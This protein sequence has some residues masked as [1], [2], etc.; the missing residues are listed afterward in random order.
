MTDE[1]AWRWPAT[2]QRAGRGRRRRRAGPRRR[3]AATSADRLPIGAAGHEHAA[4]AGGQPGEVGDPAQRLVL[5]V[6]RAGALEPRAAVDGRGADDEVEQRA[7][8]VGRARDERQVPGVVDR[9][10]RR[11][12][13]VAKTPA[14]RGRR[15][16][17]RD[18]LRRRPRPARPRSAGRRAAAGP[19]AA[20]QRRSRGP[21]RRA[22]PTSSSKACTRVESTA[23]AGRP[24][25]P[26]H[27]ARY[28]GRHAGA[29]TWSQIIDPGWAQALAPG[30]RRCARWATSSGRRSRPGAGTCRAATT[31]CARS[32]SR[33]TTCASSSSART[34]TRRRATRSGLLLG[35]SRRPAAA[36]E[37]GEHLHRAA[38]RP[39]R[40]RPDDRRP[41]PVDGAGRPAAQP[42]PHRGPRQAGEPPGQGLGDGH[43][44]AIEALVARGGPLVAVLWGR[45]AQSL[46]PCSA[47]SPGSS[48]PTRHRCRPTRGSSAPARSAGPTRCWSPPAARPSTGG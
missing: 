7:A 20:A 13:H 4:G 5:G 9:D 29:P 16:P 6:D 48:R 14:P 12:E 30:G 37:P 25:R 40:G 41:H 36:E 43:G 27:G 11:G 28:C 23:A 44:R 1:W 10:A 18:G 45:D 15:C 33:S 24:E 39:R 26:G 42:R 31:S 47:T 3:R 19:A 8:S 32:A 21:P 35:G 2:S 17:P 38:Q 46:A 22:L 34:P